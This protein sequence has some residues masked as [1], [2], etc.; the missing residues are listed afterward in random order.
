MRPD[1]EMTAKLWSSRRRNERIQT[2]LAQRRGLNHGEKKQAN[3]INLSEEGD[4]LLLGVFSP[5]KYQLHRTRRSNG[6]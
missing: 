6:G 3:G 4:Y 1:V 2:V 5:G